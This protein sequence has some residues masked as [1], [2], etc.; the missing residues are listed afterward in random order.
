MNKKEGGDWKD[1][2]HIKGGGEGREERR[3]NCKDLC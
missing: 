2:N 1:G 3:Q